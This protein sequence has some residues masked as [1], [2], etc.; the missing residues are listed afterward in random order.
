MKALVGAE[1]F[2]SGKY[3]A[4]AR[5]FQNLIE[6]DTCPDFLTLPAYDMLVAQE[7]YA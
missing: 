7:G 3:H 4:A 1:R 5:L 6:A 2:A